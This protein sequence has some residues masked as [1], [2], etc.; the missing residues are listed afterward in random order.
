M[1]SGGCEAL[2]RACVTVQAAQV[3]TGMRRTVYRY[4]RYRYTVPHRYVQ[5]LYRY[6]TAQVHRTA[7]TRRTVYAVRNGV[8][9]YVTV[10]LS[11]I[12]GVLNL[13]EG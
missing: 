4:G 6:R 10:C 7:G 3:R 1:T 8:S 12:L 13:S 11:V 9:R 5:V 2:L